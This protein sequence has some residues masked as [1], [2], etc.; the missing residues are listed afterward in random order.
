MKE[1]LLKIFI[2]QKGVGKII[3]LMMNIF[4]LI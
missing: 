1:K 3:R 2:P 4:K